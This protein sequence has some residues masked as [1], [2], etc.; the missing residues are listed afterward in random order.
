METAIRKKR[1]TLTHSP[2]DYGGFA[3]L[4]S[5]V[6]S[7]KILI[8]FIASRNKRSLKNL[9]GKIGFRDDYDYK[10]MRN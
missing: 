2:F 8:D 3:L 7:D 10:L 9:K 1:K 6:L 4:E 5:V